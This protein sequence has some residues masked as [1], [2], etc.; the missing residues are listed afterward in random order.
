MFIAS[1]ILCALMQEE[2][3]G[4]PLNFLNFDA[5]A[6]GVVAVS[7]NGV[8]LSK[9]EEEG[10][11][12]F[13]RPGYSLARFYGRK[14]RRPGEFAVIDGLAWVSSRKVFFV[15]DPGKN[16]ISTFSEDAKLLEEFNT[17]QLRR[18]VFDDEG[19]IFFVK[20][21]TNGDKYMSEIRRYLLESGEEKVLFSTPI[22][23]VSTMMIWHPRLV[24]AP[25]TDFL[26]VT[27]G[28]REG[29]Y[30]LDKHSGKELHRWNPKL[31]RV[32]LSRSFRKRYVKNFRDRSYLQDVPG[33]GIE[34]SYRDHWPLLHQLLVDK[35]DRLWVF[36]HRENS[37]M[38]VPFRVYDKTGALLGRGRLPGMPQVFDKTHLYLIENREEKT[39]LVRY[40]VRDLI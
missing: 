12:M 8:M 37:E 5:F 27:H 34:I 30:V 39:M 13:M 25:G 7:E 4:M 11:L 22:E 19:T 18:P 21:A 3:W 1:M 14:G 9:H 10:R 35:D 16:R 24:Y 2:A 6:T 33:N 29:I 15:T 23:V 31:P 32:S 36:L 40:V 28:G 20:R 26:A 38:P 17:P